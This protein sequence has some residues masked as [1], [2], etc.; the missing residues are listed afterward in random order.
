VELSNEGNPDLSFYSN[1]ASSKNIRS[2][3]LKR[4]REEGRGKREEGRGKREEGR[5]KKFMCFSLS[6]TPNP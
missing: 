1:C 6:L 3:K 5:G 4:K 2:Q